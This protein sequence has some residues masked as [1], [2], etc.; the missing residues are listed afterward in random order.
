MVVAR[1]IRGGTAEACGSL[2]EGDEILE[3]NEIELRGK[4]VDEV[5]DILAS[6]R[7]TLTFLVVPTRQHV[8]VSPI[9]GGVGRDHGTSRTGVVHLKVNHSQCGH[10][11]IYLLHIFFFVKSIFVVLQVQVPLLFQFQS[12]RILNL[13]N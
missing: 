2:N 4:T 9:G 10:F 1:I 7:G 8:T 12:L 6:M 11:R 3:V 13:V 5:C